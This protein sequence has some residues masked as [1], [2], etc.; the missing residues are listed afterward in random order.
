MENLKLGLISFLISSSV[1]AKQVIGIGEYNYGPETPENIACQMAEDRAKEHALTKF[2]GEEIKIS[3]LEE[4][5]DEYCTLNKETNNEVKG[6]IKDILNRKITHT[7]HLGHKTCTVTIKAEVER[8]INQIK[9]QIFEKDFKYKVGDKIR[10]SGISNK[11]GYLYIFNKYNNSLNHFYTQEI[12]EVNKK[13]SLPSKEKEIVA[14]LPEQ[15]KESREMLVFLFS[16]EAIYI[17]ANYTQSEFNMLLRS[18][19]FDK[20]RVINEYVY[21]MRSL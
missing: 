5:K 2:L 15:Q 14:V 1:F 12:G 17:Q 10:F 21:I 9:F 13:F 18:L 4:C 20:H 19:P 8:L 6:A 11:N 3:V 7:K 16:E